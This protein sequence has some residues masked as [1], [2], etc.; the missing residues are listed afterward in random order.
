MSIARCE[1]CDHVAAK[2]DSLTRMG[3][4]YDTRKASLRG[5]HCGFCAGQLRP[6][7]KGETESCIVDARLGAPKVVRKVPT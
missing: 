6:K 2:R 4:R 7:R 1:F 3:Y 5:Y